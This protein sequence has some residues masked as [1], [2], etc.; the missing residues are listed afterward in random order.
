[1]RGKA[2]EGGCQGSGKRISHCVTWAL[3]GSGLPGSDLSSHPKILYNHHGS[4]PPAPLGRRFQ[5]RDGSFKKEGPCPAPIAI[6][7]PPSGGRGGESI[8]PW[9]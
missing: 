5:G 4:A 3:K 2:S 7:T 1:M 6:I 9:V 8:A